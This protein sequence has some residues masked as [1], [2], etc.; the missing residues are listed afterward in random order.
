MVAVCAGTHTVD[1][2][3]RRAYVFRGVD[4]RAFA[5]RLEHLPG[6][7][8]VHCN[9]I[10][11]GNHKEAFEQ[12]VRRCAQRLQRLGPRLVERSLPEHG[13]GGEAEEEE[14]AV[15]VGISLGPYCLKN[16]AFVDCEL[17]Y[18][19][20][21]PA[22]GETSNFNDTPHGSDGDEGGNRDHDS[23]TPTFDYAGLVRCESTVGLS[24]SR[25]RKHGADDE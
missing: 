14:E 6:V 11:L 20:E 8:N 1:S 22:V 7:I 25:K 18:P 19:F 21:P 5:V 15:E 4:N 3:M 23:N 17:K 10:E 13:G 16:L 9:R 2:V 24:D 12:R